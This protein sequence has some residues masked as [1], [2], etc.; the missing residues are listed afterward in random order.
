[1]D[2]F[3]LQALLNGVLLG[4]LYVLLAIGLN[5][6][7]G[8]LK[9]IN[10][11]HG[12]LVMLGMYIVYWVTIMFNINPLL[13][14]P[15]S[16][17]SLAVVGIVAYLTVLSPVLR[18]TALEQL[19]I[20]VGLG[21]FLQ[22]L[23]QV[24]WQTDYRLLKLSPVSI[25]IGN[26]FIS[27]TLLIVFLISLIAS[28]VL[29]IFLMRTHMGVKIRAVTQDPEMA[30]LCGIDIRKIHYIVVA[31]GFGLAGLA[32]GLLVMMFPT[33]PAAGIVYG[34]IAWIIMVVGGLGSILGAFLGGMLI[35]IVE[36]LSATLWNV[37]LA[38]AIAFAI[39]ILVIALRP[40]GI[41][42]ARARV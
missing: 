3:F 42:G 5:L 13:A 41:L 15:L 38:R 18:S 1:M 36:V 33:Y 22:G 25:N 32:G 8:V 19:L 21:L 7:T 11:A 39:F 23:A 35:G 26:L 31:L 4:G 2:S 12:D 10:F 17:A 40:T 9:I 24:L 30:S 6:V 34:L 20:T 29:Y 37:E 14:T 27:Q 16:F 28:I